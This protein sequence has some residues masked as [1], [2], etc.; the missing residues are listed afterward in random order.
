MK[1]ARR[2]AAA[3]GRGAAAALHRARRRSRRAASSSTCWRSPPWCG[4]CAT[5]RAWGST[6]GFVLGLAA[7]LDAAHWLG[8]H[9]LVLALLGYVVGRLSR[10]L[11][12]DSAR[13]QFVL[14]VRRHRWSTRPG[15][16][17][18]ELGG[19]RRLALP[20]R[21]AWW[22][23]GRRHRAARHA[24]PARAASDSGAG[25]PCSAMQPSNQLRERRE[26]R[27][28]A[29]RR[30]L[31]LGGLRPGRCWACCACR[32]CEHDEYAGLAKENR[33]RLEVLRAPRGAIYDRNGEL[34]ADSAPSFG[35]VFRPVPGRE[36]AA[37]RCETMSPAWLARVGGAGRGSTRPRCGAAVGRRQP[38]RPERGAPARRAVRDA[39]RRSRRRAS[40]L[41]GIEVQVEPL[42]RYPHGTL[43]A[44]L[45][46]Y[47]GEINDAELDTLAAA[48]YRPGDLIGRTGV[49][50]SYEDILRGQDGA[51]FVVV[52]ATGRRVSTL[53][54]GAAA[55]AG[56][57]A[58][59]GAHARPQ[60]AAGAR[61]GDG[62]RRARRGGGARSA[63]RRHPRAGEP[64]GVRPERVLAR[65]QPRA[66]AG[67]DR[68]AAR[69]RCSTAPSRASIRPGSTFKIVTMLA[70]LA[71]RRGPRRHAAGAVPRRLRATA[72]ARSAAGSTRATARSTSS[73]RSSTRA[74]STST[75]SGSSSGST[76]LEETARRCGLGDAH[77]HRPAAGDAGPDP[78]RGLVRPALGRRA[79]AQGPAAEPRDRAG[80]AAAHAA[81]ARADGRR[82]RERRPARCARTWC[83]RRAR[84]RGRSA[85]ARPAQPGL[86]ADPAIWDAV[87]RGAW[88]WW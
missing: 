11:V 13:T 74:T 15:S 27:F 42:R 12:R 61:G 25:G 17:A 9:A 55:A 85:P 18:F 77:R 6:F 49:E 56:A 54:R 58:R 80:R 87:H 14:L 73:A 67:A 76:R 64:A 48:G 69:T 70:A 1:G 8:R 31:A 2:A 72:A 66:L 24:A 5:A 65:P 43:A 75:R 16:L 86:A 79:L 10:T 29:A 59:P 52:N 41:P 3:R 62:G 39:G 82:G 22:S 4:R 84:R 37:R 36:R 50:R 21:G 78:E 81:P 71:P 44:H 88:S 38:H 20:A 83:E 45:L 63:R 53:E 46:G 60:G 19:R 23:R 68:A 34:L 26:Q 35:I 28:R 7:D 32:S 57:G 40:E 30:R 51:E 47:A 33:V